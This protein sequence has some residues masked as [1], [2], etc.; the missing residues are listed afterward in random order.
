MALAASTRLDVSAWAYVANIAIILAFSF[1]MILRDLEQKNR[2]FPWSPIILTPSFSM[3]VLLQSL[4][5]LAVLLVLT[6]FDRAYLWPCIDAV[7]LSLAGLTVVQSLPNA[8]GDR[9]KQLFALLNWAL[10]KLY[11]DLGADILRESDKFTQELLGI[12][13]VDPGGFLKD[14]QMFIQHKDRVNSPKEIA[15][16]EKEF[17]SKSSPQQQVSYLA[18][19]IAHRTTRKKWRRLTGK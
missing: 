5:V 9:A 19:K 12:Y 18:S 3:L 10:E 7:W 11:D 13:A 16:V 1:F 4:I 2:P 6:T 8:K 17:A 14:V 15:A